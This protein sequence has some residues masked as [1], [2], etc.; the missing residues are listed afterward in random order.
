[1]RLTE[2]ARIVNAGFSHPRDEDLSTSVDTMDTDPDKDPEAGGKGLG[3][4]RRNRDRPVGDAL[5]R[6]ATRQQLSVAQTGADD[7]QSAS[8]EVQSL[9]EIL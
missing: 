7:V 8:A 3:R 5:E 9:A 4:R 1:M 2:K 6:S